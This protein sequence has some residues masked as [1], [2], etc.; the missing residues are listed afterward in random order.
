MLAALLPEGFDAEKM[1][2]LEWGKQVDGVKN[3][4]EVARAPSL[5][6]EST[7]AKST[8]SR[9][10]AKSMRSRIEMLDEINKMETP[11]AADKVVRNP[12][13]PPMLGAGMPLE[14]ANSSLMRA[15]GAKLLHRELATRSRLTRDK[16]DG[17]Q[18]SIGKCSCHQFNCIFTFKKFGLQSVHPLSA[19]ERFPWTMESLKALLCQLDCTV[20]RCV[21]NSTRATKQSV[22]TKIK[23]RTA[24]T[25]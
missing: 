5:V 23:H 6:P 4:P 21:E 15:V 24:R 11:A 2:V 10:C 13:L 14:G 3:F 7:G 19:A 25:R 1:A 18:R 12:K 20:E 8:G 22:P 9:C 16:Q 17:Q